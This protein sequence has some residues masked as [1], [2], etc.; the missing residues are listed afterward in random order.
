MFVKITQNNKQN[1]N[2]NAANNEPLENLEREQQ[3]GPWT[4]VERWRTSIIYDVATYAFDCHNSLRLNRNASNITVKLHLIQR[5]GVQLLWG[6]NSNM[7]FEVNMLLPDHIVT[8][9]QV[10]WINACL[11]LKI[12]YLKNWFLSLIKKIYCRWFQ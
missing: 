8:Y 12:K 6:L 3:W 4:T 7:F 5:T 1:I 9:S 10:T 11:L 2:H